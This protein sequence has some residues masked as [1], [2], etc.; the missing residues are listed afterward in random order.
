MKKMGFRTKLF[1][2]YS[3]IVFFVIIIGFS[4]VYYYIMKRL[5]AE[6]I[7]NMDLSV[8]EMTGQMDSVIKEM[9][10]IAIEI[11][12]NPTIQEY[13]QNQR[14]SG[15][16]EQYSNMQNMAYNTL[17]SLS[18]VNLGSLRV[19]IYNQYGSYTSIGI[20][21]DQRV[22]DDRTAMREYEK[23]FESLI[24][25]HNN[26]KVLLPHKD[27]WTNDEEKQMISVVREIV[28]INSYAS[29][30]IAEVQYPVRK[31]KR[32]FEN[33]LEQKQYLFSKSGV[34]LY[35]NEQAEEN[36]SADYLL[37]IIGQDELGNK[38]CCIGGENGYLS[39]R[40]SG[41]TDWYFAAFRSKKA[42]YSAIYPII[43]VVLMVAI[44]IL[45]I[46]LV[47]IAV[48]A[49][50]L[51]R[52]LSKLQQKIRF[53]VTSDDAGDC[54]KEKSSQRDEIWMIDAAFDSLYQNLL[55]SQDELNYLKVQE[56]K[57]QM[58]AVQAQMNPHFLYNILSV[59]SAVSLDYQAYEVM[60][61]CKALS[62]MLRYS[63]SF[64]YNMVPFAEEINHTENY[65]E[66]MHCRFKDNIGYQFQ[67]QE[68]LKEVM[69]P[70][71]ILQPIVENCFQHG[72]SE[73]KPPWKIYVEGGI[74]EKRWFIR[75]LDNG[76]GFH[77]G[78]LEKLEKKLD[79]WQ[80]NISDDIGNL[81]IGGYGLSNVIIRLKIIYGVGATFRVYS[82]QKEK[83]Q[84]CVVEI[85]GDL[86][87]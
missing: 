61:M 1:I 77:G 72:F 32:I 49:S 71:L 6:V 39:F 9:D 21:T 26:S 44:L 37:D 75:V 22:I 68:E 64:S 69:V 15:I 62:S 48:I 86:V 70:K 3:L 43:G 20:P 52:P 31:L 10:H 50:H 17:I 33:T 2:Y 8:K 53:V 36:T 81:G 29:F 30:G 51:T 73:V 16:T 38:K 84:F 5:E 58:L 60:D 14:K 66:L 56:I 74:T 76:A 34:F 83:E 67:I 46:M 27:F 79:H 45:G 12:A 19:S 65:L 85:G 28:D 82:T 78:D 41:E 54:E 55:H 18:A 4:A 11:V 40:K 13:M 47:F 80:E 35:S 57:M 59:I 63:G 87:V 7:Q 23:W 42:L 25:E 24:P